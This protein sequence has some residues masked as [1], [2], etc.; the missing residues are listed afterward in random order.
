MTKS[1]S[2]RSKLAL[3][4][5][6]FA[7][8]GLVFA[9]PEAFA[10]QVAV[11]E[12]VVTARKR[13]E[14]L[15]DVPLSITAFSSDMIEKS[16][17]RSVG[18][19]AKLTSSLV[20]ETSFVPQDTRP[21][22]R[23]LS[24]TRG[25]QPIGVLLDG[26]DISSESLLTGGGGIGMNLRLVDAE[27]IE[28]V[29]GPQSALY[30][31]V[32]FGGA[33]NYISKKPGD[34]FEGRL[35]ADVGDHGQAEVTGSIA[36]PVS[37]TVGLRL[38]A[39]YAQHNGF[40]DN[41][42][43]G[44]GI[45]GY[46]SYGA[47]LSASF[48]ASE[49]FTVDVRASYS[50]DENE[51]AAQYFLGAANGGTILTNLPAGAQP[52]IDAGILPAQT[53]LAPF[54]NFAPVQ[55]GLITLSLDPRTGEDY[56]GSDVDAIYASLITEY[57][58]GT[59]KLN[60][61][62]GYS[63]VDGFYRVDTDFYAEPDAPVLF[64]T[65]GGIA[66]P[67]PNTFESSASTNV[68]QIN[69]EVRIGDLESDGFRWAVGG[70]YWDENYVQLDRNLITVV[71]GAPGVSSAALNTR[72]AMPSPERPT[73][74]DTE[75]WSVYGIFEYDISEKLAASVEARYSDESFSYVWPNGGAAVSVFGPPADAGAFTTFM[76]SDSDNFFAPKFTLEYQTTDDALI[77]ASVS[78]GVKPGGF[79]TVAAP[80]IENAR[81]TAETVWNYEVGTKTSWA[82]GR[83][84][85]NGAVFLMK[86]TD[87]QF[88]QQ[89]PDD[90]SPNGLTGRTA[91]AADSE[92]RGFE[93]DFAAAPAD[94]VSLNA[95]YTFL[96]TEYTD[97]SQFSNTP[98]AIAGARNCTPT[99]LNGVPGCIIDSTGS[100][101][102]RA[103]KHA[104]NLSA[105]YRTPITNELEL[106]GVIDA[107]YQSNRGNDTAEA[108]FYPSYW[109]VDAR[110]GVENEIW[111]VYA[112][113]TNI[114]GDDTVRGGTGFGDFTAF[115]NIGY[116]LNAPPKTQLGVRASYS[117]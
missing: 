33:I 110:L 91:N 40:Y 84:I 48:E 87:K 37:D 19:I 51:P 107:Q 95:G 41:A 7:L 3:R 16:G 106:F 113:G 98:L 35:F 100:R 99:T 47:A 27:R 80:L 25:R 52:L 74:R 82:D 18:D 70:L 93:V 78:K 54:G 58:F 75:H 55:E 59:V 68:R 108:H 62:T 17:I 39:T 6:V 72:L 43:S 42:I 57:D 20:F 64:P 104:L 109:N 12:I 38:N 66:E 36:G 81:Y 13:A 105:G 88:Q 5:S 115:G 32:A 116:A 73:R 83:L 94:G 53:R 14:S 67:L 2:L 23:G 49:N 56:E 8:S 22:I 34:E 86:Y 85:A 90:T 112:Y 30:G 11:E 76:A 26:I 45:G 50:K 63:E 28:V 65:P 69:Q 111:S 61:W 77:Y 71:V 15:Q 31:R 10:Q 1:K 96:D 102:E 117:W 21:V 9:A 44:E 79:S 97:F 29:K 4:S 89:I 92:V 103:P 60:T 46:E 24:A 101:I 114:L